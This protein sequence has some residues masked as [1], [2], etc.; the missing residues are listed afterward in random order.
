MTLSP[1]LLRC[2]H[3]AEPRGLNTRTPRFSWALRGDGHDRVQTAW[4]IVV[5]VDPQQVAAGKGDWWDSDRVE[6]NDTLLVPYSGR[7]LESDLRLF[8][9]VRSWDETGEPGP[10]SEPACFWTGLL[11]ASDWTAEWIARSYV[12]PSGYDAPQDTNYD[13][14]FNA[15]PPDQMRRE[16]SLQ[17]PVRSAILYA[18]ALGLYEVSVNGQRLGDEV[19]APGWT[20]YHRRVP[21]QIYDATDL[22]VEG[23]NAVGVL[24]GEGWYAGRIGMSKKHQGAIYGGRPMFLGQ[25]HVTYEDG[26][27]EVIATD[28]TWRTARGGIVYSDLLEGETYDARLETEGWTEPGFDDAE[29]WQVETDTPA[30]TAPKIEAQRCQPVRETA[31]ISATH[32]GTRPDGEMIFD[33]G[34][35][36]SG[37][38]SVSLKGAAGDR[39]V[40]RHA[41]RLTEEGDLYVGNLRGIGAQETYICRDD[42]AVTYQPRFT[43]HGFQYVGV[44]APRGVGPND[45]SITAIA[46]HTDAPVTGFFET[47]DEMVNRLVS[48]IEWGQRSNFIS[49]PTDCPQRNE[50]LGWIADAQ[51]FWNTAACMMDVAGLTTKFMLDIADTETEGG[52]ADIAPSGPAYAHIWE[53]PRGAPAWGDG[54]I[55]LPWIQ[56]LRYADTE[57]LDEHYGVM[58]RWI[59]RIEAENPSYL[60]LNYLNR[61]YGDWLS[62]GRATPRGVVNTAYWAFLAQIMREVAS[63]LNRR[64][65]AARFDAMFRQVCAA[66]RDAYVHPDGTIEGDTQTGYLLA[67]DFGLLDDAQRG[68]AAERLVAAIDAADGHLQTGF[69]GVRHLCPVLTAVGAEGRAFDL[70]LKDTYPSWGFS[71]RHGATTIWERW[72]GWT[73]EQGFQSVNMNSFNHY[74]YGSVGEWLFGDVAGIRPDPERPGFRRILMQPRFDARLGRVSARYGSHSGEIASAYDFAGHE[75]IWRVTLPANTSA[76]VVLPEGSVTRNGHGWSG[77]EIG[78]GTHEFRIVL[79]TSAK[80]HSRELPETATTGSS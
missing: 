1:H 26:S 59:D 13:N 69:L 53:P 79:G 36:L 28:G 10:W 61:N 37:Y 8:W 78:S 41:E 47:G 50:R 62:V 64:T 22:V 34:Q 43:F 19:F 76:A 23:R 18:T 70:L 25:V 32:I 40:F 17:K 72:D 14:P 60:R 16:F 5:G 58:K 71:I 65:D 48:N 74:C 2:E 73:P 21:Y 80:R 55:I 9:S 63:A 46:I 42:A 54:V 35:N 68:K 11:D 52:V 66:F 20:D 3:L 27:R 24:L 29:W 33:T 67:L 4:R 75:V 12:A 44:R 39:F 56:Y 15:L 57:L 31:E 6:G 49:V 45:L 30:P 7:R 51:V 77:E 38:L